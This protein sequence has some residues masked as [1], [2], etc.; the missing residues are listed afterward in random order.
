MLH[1]I[2]TKPV[3][4]RAINQPPS[5][6]IQIVLDSFL[7]ECLVCIQQLGRDSI[8]RTKAHIRAV[9]QIAV[10]LWPKQI[11]HELDF[12]SRGA[13][14]EAKVVVRRPRLLRDVDQVRQP[15]ILHLPGIA[16][17][18]CVVPLSVKTI[19]RLPQMKVLRDQAWVDVDGRALIV[20]RHVKCAVIHDVV[21][22]HAN[23]KPMRYLHEPNQLRLR[24][25]PRPHRVPLI[26]RPQIKRV[27]HVIPHR[28][29][30][31]SL[32]RRRQPQ[33]RVSCLRQLR[34]FVRDLHPRRIEVLQHR[35]SRSHSVHK[36]KQE[37][38]EARAPSARVHESD[39][40]VVG[41]G[42]GGRNGGAT[43]RR[44][45][46]IKRAGWEAYLIRFLLP[47]EIRI[48]QTFGQFRA[49]KDARQVDAVF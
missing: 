41:R 19:L 33:R 29:T 48:S 11:T 15:Q 2:E 9:G 18:A 32:R 43:G 13:L 28:Q 40:A 31:R 49:E 30:A 3:S 36:K 34:D 12:R 23:P 47:Q 39:G 37:E 8:S 25:I 7:I 1:R 20:S 21:K 16:P 35:L 24:P 5:R 10:L 38:N 44:I 22:I 42:H 27:P 6:A 26:L 45:L 46:S 17:R 14:R 4:L